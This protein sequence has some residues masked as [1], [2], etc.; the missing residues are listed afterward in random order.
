MVKRVFINI[1]EQNRAMAQALRSGEPKQTIIILRSD[2]LASKLQ[3]AI[4]IALNVPNLSSKMQQLIKKVVTRWEEEPDPSSYISKTLNI[5]TNAKIRFEARLGKD[6]EPEWN[7]LLEAAIDQCGHDYEVLEYVLNGIIAQLTTQSVSV[8]LPNAIKAIYETA[9]DR[10]EFEHLLETKSDPKEYLLDRLRALRRDLTDTDES[11]RLFG[12]LEAHKDDGNN[13]KSQALVVRD[14]PAE[15]RAILPVHVPAEAVVS[16]EEKAGPLTR[17]VLTGELKLQHVPAYFYLDV[18]DQIEDAVV[19]ST[20]KQALYARITAEFGDQRRIEIEDAVNS[21]YEISELAKQV[22]KEPGMEKWRKALEEVENSVLKSAY[23]YIIQLSFAYS[24]LSLVHFTN[25]LEMMSKFCHDITFMIK[26][27][28]IEKLLALDINDGDPIAL[29]QHGT[30]IL[31]PGSPKVIDG[32]DSYQEPVFISV[33]RNQC[34]VSTLGG[35]VLRIM[36]DLPEN[37]TIGMP[38]ALLYGNRLIATFQVST[39]NNGIISLLDSKAGAQF[40]VKLRIPDLPPN[41]NLVLSVADDEVNISVDGINIRTL[42]LA[43]IR[44]APILDLKDNT[45]NVPKNAILRFRAP[46]ANFYIQTFLETCQETPSEKQAEL[47]ANA[48]HLLCL[49]YDKSNAS[50][51]LLFTEDIKVV[52]SATATLFSNISEKTTYS[53]ARTTSGLI[54]LVVNGNSPLELAV[55]LVHEDGHGYGRKVLPRPFSRYITLDASKQLLGTT[56]LARA[57][58]EEV[59]EIFAEICVLRFAVR[60]LEKQVIDYG[61][62]DFFIR[63]SSTHIQ[64]ELDGLDG[65]IDLGNLTEEGKAL[66]DSFTNEFNQLKTRLKQLEGTKA[67]NKAD[68]FNGVAPCK[69]EAIEKDSEDA[70]IMG[71]DHLLDHKV[72]A[73][74][75]VRKE[76]LETMHA[77]QLVS[78]GRKALPSPHAVGLQPLVEEAITLAARSEAVAFES[79]RTEED[80]KRLMIDLN[81]RRI[82]DPRLAYILKTLKR[83]YP[84]KYGKTKKQLDYSW[85]GDISPFSPW[86]SILLLD[87]LSTMELRKVKIERGRFIST[88]AS[89]PRYQF[90]YYTQFN[91][92][93]FSGRGEELL[94]RYRLECDDDSLETF[95]QRLGFPKSSLTHTEKDFVRGNGT[96]SPQLA[97]QLS[98]KEGAIKLLLSR[99]ESKNATLL[100]PS[101]NNPSKYASLGF[102]RFVASIFSDSGGTL[103]S[104]KA[105]LGAF[106]KGE[107]NEQ[108]WRAL[109]AFAGFETMPF[110]PKDMAQVKE[111]LAHPALV[112]ESGITVIP[113][114][115]NFASFKTTMFWHPRFYGTGFTLL[116]RCELSLDE[117]GYSKLVECI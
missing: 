74:E 95:K 86:N 85:P 83:L 89:L 78:I 84:E 55:S 48:F 111:I 17:A 110:D 109:L 63:S 108:N 8:V 5:L 80:I 58:E 76:D 102:N 51:V 11:K 37:C 27:S 16:L 59:Q 54:Q 67:A 7:R 82:K 106:D 10:N 42:S 43:E 35:K 13:K 66:V 72:A 116:A 36:R 87:V 104:G 113:F 93:L 44:S 57:F 19:R 4:S 38:A 115:V 30:F 53:A 91:H 31:Q 96:V 73:A 60:A 14:L 64:L 46:N 101:V 88:F 68:R 2:D 107:V 47:L 3:T 12:A 34:Y 75:I 29:I 32:L 112:T 69:G 94:R 71:V 117:K 1:S 9:F 52:P 65:Q 81:F 92:P 90:L 22:V 103:V 18:R 40:E 24:K 6:Y 114:P 98:S 45:A 33:V 97:G 105:V 15:V 21:F 41:A 61:E 79:S 26:E 99:R 20:W 100:A 62:I 23:E 25:T 56:T 50:S 49:T 28:S 77:R 70:I 39:D